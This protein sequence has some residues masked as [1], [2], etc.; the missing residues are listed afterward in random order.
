MYKI[1]TKMKIL[2]IWRGP[3]PYRIDFFNELGKYCDLTVFFERSPSNISDKNI[4]WFNEN[5]RNFKG[6]YL[7]GHLFLKKIWFC[8]GIFK[9]LKQLRQFDLIVVGMYSTPTQAIL[10]LLMKLLKI[11]YILNSDGGFIK[12]EKYIIYKIKRTF[13]KGAFAYLSS[14]QKHPHT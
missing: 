3:S 2:F 7:K 4:T 10:I 9:Y 14:S 12:K 1:K 13:I 8:Y 11:K 5:F 6:I